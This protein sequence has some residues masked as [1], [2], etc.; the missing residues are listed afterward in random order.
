MGTFGDLDNWGFV[1]TWGLA[2]FCG[3]CPV[4]RVRAREVLG[5]GNWTP[6]DISPREE[7]LVRIRTNRFP[8]CNFE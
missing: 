3:P 8:R 6:S 4:D 7:I 5:L 1:V 2:R